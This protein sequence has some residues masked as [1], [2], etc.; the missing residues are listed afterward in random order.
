MAQQGDGVPFR[1]GPVR[2]FLAAG[3][4][5][6]DEVLVRQAAS[7][8]K[9]TRTN[10]MLR[11][12]LGDGLLTSEGEQWRRSRQRAQPAFHRQ[13][14]AALAPAMTRAAEELIAAWSVGGEQRVDMHCEMMR[15][16]L[17][18][19]ARTLFSAEA[20]QADEFGQALAIVLPFFERRFSA[21]LPLPLWVPTRGN[22]DFESAL[23]SINR[24]VAGVIA[25]R[26]GGRCPARDTPDLLDLLMGAPDGDTEAMTDAQLRDEVITM[27][28]AGH[29]TTASALTWTFYLL[30]LHP[31]VLGALRRELADRLRQRVPR[32]EDLAQLPLL[33]RVVKESM[34]L[35][36]PVPL[37]DRTVSKPCE[38]AGHRLRR[39]DL[40]VLSPWLTHR[41]ERVW[42]NA[43][44]FD[45]DNFLP[46]REASRPRGAYFPFGAGTRK[47]IGEGFAMMEARLIL[48][49]VLP[50]VEFTFDHR[51][52]VVPQSQVTLRPQGGMPM[53]I[54]LTGGQSCAS[55]A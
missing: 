28:T 27:F 10:E 23:A 37:L 34:R 24:I 6:A 11:I 41:M 19:A 33:E 15:L 20:D 54:R 17:R 9:Q 32:F 8:S 29:E 35:Y 1:A 44:R 2:G 18:I 49:T 36:P 26:R 45:P 47:C 53:W 31:E 43:A 21:L 5:E 16:T 3:P 40:V 12:A 25:A 46:G 14:V 39:G 42:P 52:A 48:A 30:S 51:H 7:F 22:R 38:V 13:Y 50:R 4:T 55:A